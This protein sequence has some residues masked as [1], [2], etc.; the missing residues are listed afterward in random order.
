M[1]WTATK[2]RKNTGADDWFGA[3]ES[4]A[5]VAT[6]IDGSGSAPEVV[7]IAVVIIVWLKKRTPL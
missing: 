5:N 7:D 4:T 6:C 2:R 3:I 1:R